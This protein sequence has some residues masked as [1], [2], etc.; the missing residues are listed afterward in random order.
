MR[1]SH[2]ES[3]PPSGFNW[4]ALRLVLPWLGEFRGR[5]ALAMLC[6]VL[7]KV[8]SIGAPYLLKHVV[9]GLEPAG[10]SVCLCANLPPAGRAWQKAANSSRMAAR[11]KLA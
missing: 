4:S 3:P 10:P 7:A 5:I 9:D 8:G 2:H 1:H 11:L 6:L